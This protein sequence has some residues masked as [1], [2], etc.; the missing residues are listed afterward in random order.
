M[1]QSEISTANKCNSLLN[2][3]LRVKYIEK[4]IS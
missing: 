3:I 4:N 1:M 2:Y